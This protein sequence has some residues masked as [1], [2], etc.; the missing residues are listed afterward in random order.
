MSRGCNRSE[1]YILGIDQSTQGTKGVL[2]DE[3]GRIVGR[4]DRPHRQIINDEGWVS[5]SLSEIWENSIAV[6]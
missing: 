1:F 3:T 2:V 5:H 4:A 6:L